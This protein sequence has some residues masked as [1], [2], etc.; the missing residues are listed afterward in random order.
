MLF[1][2]ASPIAVGIY[3]KLNRRTYRGWPRRTAQSHCTAT[4]PV[5]QLLGVRSNSWLLQ[6]FWDLEVYEPLWP[7]PV[8]PT[9]VQICAQY[10]T[11]MDL[12]HFG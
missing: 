4:K 7:F 5:N 2:D 10:S 6:S 8:V 11:W 9:L 3:Q 1:I 12:R